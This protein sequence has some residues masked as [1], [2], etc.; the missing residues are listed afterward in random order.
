MFSDLSIVY[1]SAA[2]SKVSFM[3]TFFKYITDNPCNLFVF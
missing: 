3:I 1:N 2:D